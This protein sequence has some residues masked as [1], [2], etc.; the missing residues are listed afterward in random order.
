M[1]PSGIYTMWKGQEQPRHLLEGFCWAGLHKNFFCGMSICAT[2]LEF[3]FEA[4][5]KRWNGKPGSDMDPVFQEVVLVKHTAT[6][7]I[8]V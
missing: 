7:I 3:E 6:L 4:R 2:G 5:E 8:Q 1:A